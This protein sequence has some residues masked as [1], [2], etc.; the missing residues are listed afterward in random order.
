MGGV[1]CG[2]GALALGACR[3]G[4]VAAQSGSVSGASPLPLPV[5]EIETPARLDE[6]S[7]FGAG[8]SGRISTRDGAV[9]ASGLSTTARFGSWRVGATG[10]YGAGADGGSSVRSAAGEIEAAR[11]R[12]HVVF[13]RVDVSG[14]GVLFGERLELLSRTSRLPFAR[15]GT[16]DFVPASSVRG[17]DGAAVSWRQAGA[18]G[19]GDAARESW[20]AWAFAGRSRR[21]SSDEPAPLGATGALLP[22]GGSTLLA[23][24]MGW[25]GGSVVASLA[26]RTRSDAWDAGIEATVSRAGFAALADVG[27]SSPP[28]R[29]RGRWRYREGDARPIAG[30]VSAEAHSRLARVVVRASGGAFGATGA[31]ERRELE[32]RLGTSRGLGP[33]SVRLGRTGTTGFTA[34]DGFTARHERYAV[35]DL[36]VAR[37][38]G[39]VFAVTATRRERGSESGSK[40]GTS[41]GGRL[42]LTWR[43][44]ARLEIRVEA[45]RAKADAP[46]WSSGVFAGG[47]TALRSRTRAGVAASARGE[48]RAGTWRLGGVVEG[49]EDERGR[50]TTAATLWIEKSIP[51]FADGNETRTS[52]G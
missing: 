22:I 39:R 26:A 34:A 9:S 28:F 30:E 3:A 2:I 32:A 50:G 52:R 42:G 43:R 16:P 51:F 44:R 21:G 27:F 46:A 17:L 15:A 23:P 31:V 37:A 4:P 36:E 47:A 20:S 12:F 40:V 33:L 11:G 1:A 5:E 14:P 24:S 8:F 45:V 13:G 29:W 6:V 48:I 35:V 19:S 41:A 25:S 49:R 10:W 18:T 38:A 7:R